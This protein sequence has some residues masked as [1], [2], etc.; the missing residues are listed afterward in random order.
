MCVCV[1]TV[2]A[3]RQP[4]LPHAMPLY[5]SAEPAQAAL[6][7][8]KE[9]G[10]RDEESERGREREDDGQEEAG[11]KSEAEGERKGRAVAECTTISH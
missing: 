4:S 2:P 1:C 10:K 3:A 8:G 5:S 11:V 9:G 7:S 6:H